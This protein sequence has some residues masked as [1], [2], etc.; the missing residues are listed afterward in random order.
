MIYHFKTLGYNPIVGDSFTADTPLFIKY[1]D[2]GLIDIKPICELIGKTE[3]DALGREYDTSEKP[4]KVLC[5]SGWMKPNYIY[6]HKTNKPLYEVSEGNMSVTVTEDHSLFN[7]KQ[8]KIKPSE[9]NEQTKL[10]YYSKPIDTDRDFRWL[11][12]QRARIMAKKILD[13]TVDRVS[14]ALLNTD[15]IS[16]IE[17]FLDEFKYM[18]LGT[19][20]KTC[21]AG[22]MFLKRK[23]YTYNRER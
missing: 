3:T 8:E 10:E 11:T 14:V 21:Q 7:D 23:I 19:F 15:D 5:R 13:G 16:C 4:F 1:D 18:P 6:R 9:I 12:K 22:I 20:S 17:A 2:S